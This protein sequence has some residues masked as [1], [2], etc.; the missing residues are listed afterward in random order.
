MMVVTSYEESPLPNPPHKGEGLTWPHRLMQEHGACQ[1]LSPP[2]WGRCPAGQRGSYF[3]CKSAHLEGEMSGRTEGGA[4]AAEFD[5]GA[6][7]G[8]AL[9][10]TREEISP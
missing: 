1:D 5:A 7:N 2:L 8:T 9:R 10:R 4:V 3:K 6:D